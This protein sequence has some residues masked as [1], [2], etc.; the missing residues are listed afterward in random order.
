LIDVFYQS[1]G[2]N[3]NMLLNLSPDKRGL[4]PDNQ[5]AVLSRMAQVVN[6]TFAVN[7]AA[8]GQAHGRH[9][10]SRQQPVARAGRKP[11]Y[12]VGSRAGE[13]PMAR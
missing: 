7:L 9:F 13:R 6:D 12:L 8:G 11:G 5:L 2:R 10:Q 1:V 3:G 4:I